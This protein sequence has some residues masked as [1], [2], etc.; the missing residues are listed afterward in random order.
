[1][2]LLAYDG[3]TPEMEAAVLRLLDDMRVVPLIPDV[4]RL[5]ITIRRETKRKLPDAIVAATAVWL[6]ATLV[7]GDK[8]MANTTFRGLQTVLV[9]MAQEG[10]PS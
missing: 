2:E 9:P 8:K 10:D 4:E 7:T 5:A 3:L 6:G 1:M